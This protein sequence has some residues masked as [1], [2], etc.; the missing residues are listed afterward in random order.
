M[1]C[2]LRK[3]EWHTR[4]SARPLD[5]KGSRLEAILLVLGEE[6]GISAAESAAATPL[7]VSGKRALFRCQGTS[8]E[9]DGYG[10]SNGKLPF[11][12]RTSS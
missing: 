6:V 4:K 7:G 12:H 1:P 5:R 8:C 2:Q 3:A 9:E 11:E 10:N